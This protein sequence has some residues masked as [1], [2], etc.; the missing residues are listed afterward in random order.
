ML[1]YSKPL[2]LLLVLTIMTHPMTGNA[3]EPLYGGDPIAANLKLPTLG[4]V[5]FWTDLRWWHGWRIQRNELNSRCRV[6][7]PSHVRYFSGS[8]EA[9]EAK[10]A[11]IIAEQTWPEPPQRVVICMHGLMR[12]HRSFGSLAKRIDN[13]TSAT[14]ILF[15]YSSTR[16][17]VHSH[18]QA[19]RG[20]IEGLPGNPEIDLVG[21]SMGNIVARHA[22]ADWQT[23]GDPTGALDRLNRFVMQ[24]P[25]NQGAQIAKRLQAMNLFEMITG[26]SGLQLGVSW[27]ELQQRLATP[28]CEF[29][30]IAG[31]F[32]TGPIRNPLV[33]GASDLIVSVEEA[34]LSG[35][36]DF[37]ILPVAHSI[38]MNDARVQDAT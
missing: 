37:L 11:S 19:L 10:F 1:A 21:H 33:D 12:T 34:K 24:G 35:A 4:G 5:Q 8:R 32:D 15:G 31:S 13:E 14:S 28:P 20:L 23:T 29:G 18:A 36:S 9:C 2:S 6:L 25:P 27:D 22:I 7:S 38:M 16:A 30:I 26:H 3:D 17:P